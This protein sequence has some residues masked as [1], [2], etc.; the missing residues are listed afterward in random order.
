[1]SHHNN[2]QQTKNKT[3]IAE[4]GANKTEQALVRVRTCLGKLI[5]KNNGVSNVTPQEVSF[6]GL[7]QDYGM[8]QMA[9]FI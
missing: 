7:A 5:K 8:V 6:D 2:T 4:L 1:M 3:A 9:K